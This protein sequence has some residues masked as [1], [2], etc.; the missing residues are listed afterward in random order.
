[1]CS[2]FWT[3]GNTRGISLEYWDNTPRSPPRAG[4]DVRIHQHG[5]VDRPANS[6]RWQTPRKARRNRH[7]SQQPLIRFAPVATKVVRPLSAEGGELITHVLS[8]APPAAERVAG[9]KGET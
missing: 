3:L 1:M 4:N 5:T 7:E 6:Q 9:T 8:T 2:Y